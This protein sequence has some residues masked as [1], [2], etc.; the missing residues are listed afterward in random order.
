LYFANCFWPDFDA[1]ALELAVAEY[2]S[3]QRRFG[4]R[5]GNDTSLDNSSASNSDSANG[6]DNDK[7]SAL[8]TGDTA[9]A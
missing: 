4:L 7:S 9:H 2:Y 8:D 1:K 5:D 3:R 6:P